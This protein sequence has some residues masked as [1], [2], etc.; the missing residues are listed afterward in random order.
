MNV[1]DRIARALLVVLAIA[2]CARR[3][4]AP[5]A[6][7]PYLLVWAG[8]ADRKDPDFLAVFGGD[9]SSRKYGQLLKTYPV[10]PRGNEPQLLNRE[11]RPDGRVFAT[12]VLTGRVFTFDLARPLAGK[13]LN[14]YDPG[15]KRLLTAPIEP[16]VLPNGDVAVTCADRMRYRGAPREVLEAPGGL[17]AL[18]A[19][20]K[21]EGEHSG[22]HPSARSLVVAPYGG[23]VSRRLGIL[24]TTNRGHGFTPTTTGPVQPGISVQ[25]W[26]LRDL[27]VQK[28]VLLPAG[29]RG[30]ENLGPTLPRFLHRSPMLVVNTHEGGAL[31]ASD[32]LGVA[33]PAFRL[34]FDFGAGSLPSGLVITPD[35]R[36][37]VVA[38]TG[39]NRLVALD[40]TDPWAPKPV[41]TL[42][43]A[44]GA[45]GGKGAGPSTLTISA[46]GARIA[47][48][49]Y[50]ITAASGTLDGDRRV[51]V[52]RLDPLT[53]QLRLDTDFRGDGEGQAGVDFGRTTW[54][55]GET[56]AARPRGLLFIAPV[57]ED[58]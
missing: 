35:D 34:V 1:L 17:V 12:G 2:G 37:L 45:R 20:G 11:P 30:E 53:G 18:D 54:P 44:D 16:V 9:P 15:G 58:D 33:E 57:G 5:I 41:S 13:L 50:T 14:T 26:S 32:S 22:A 3:E 48:A 31:Y 21:F 55:H 38:I 51:H 56:G 40:L 6:V 49:D 36:F 10:R 39:R 25:V 42:R 7:E 19:A 46:D 27:A 28:T 4:Q 47:V 24:V 52:V 23:A 43:L 8:D 29:P